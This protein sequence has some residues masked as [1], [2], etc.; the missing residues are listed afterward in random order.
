MDTY[1]SAIGA[2]L[3]GIALILTII[4][5]RRVLGQTE[6]LHAANDRLARE[7]FYATRFDSVFSN[8]EKVLEAVADFKV[9]V[10]PYWKETDESLE[11]ATTLGVMTDR[12]MA[13]HRAVEVMRVNRDTLELSIAGLP[14]TGVH[15]QSPSVKDDFDQLNLASSWVDGCVMACYF[16]LV[17]PTLE[18]GETQHE[19]DSKVFDMIQREWDA[20]GI[21][22]LKERRVKFLNERSEAWS[23]K[24]KRE[25]SDRQVE[26]VEQISFHFLENAQRLLKDSAR[27]LLKAYTR[28]RLE[29]ADAIERRR[30]AQPWYRATSG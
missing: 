17:S 4:I 21:T 15:G 8:V 19:T 26:T 27:E 13:V 14:T 28:D 30:R 25:D 3:A 12:E 24:R 22:E 9:S 1:I 23:A 16:A 11:L 2:V 20:G 6:E 5:T 18:N 10:H 7:T 29:N